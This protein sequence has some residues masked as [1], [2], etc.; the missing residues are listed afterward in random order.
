MAGKFW[1]IG[2]EYLKHHYLG[3]LLA[4]F[5]FCIFAPAVIGIEALDELQSAKVGEMYLCLTGIILLV[6]LFMP[7][8]RRDIRDLIAARETP[9]IQIHLIRLL[10]SM[11]I[12]VLLTVLFLLRMRQGE[13]EFS[14]IKL[15]AGTLANAVFLGGMGIFVYGISDNLPIAYMMPMVYFILNF[16]TGKEYLGVFYLFS[17]MQGSFSEKI[18]LGTAGVLLLAAGILWR[19]RGMYLSKIQSVRLDIQG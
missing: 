9:M 19:A 15:L 1:A 11:V 14:F 4:A 16:G 2:K 17:M 6:P 12:L 3:H 18:W 10:E 7:D 5:L 8:Q 13:C